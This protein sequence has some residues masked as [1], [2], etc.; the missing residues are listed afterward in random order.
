[1]ALNAANAHAITIQVSAWAGNN[2]KSHAQIIGAT[3]AQKTQMQAAISDLITPGRECAGID[4]LCTLPGISTVTICKFK[5]SKLQRNGFVLYCSPTLQTP[6][7]GLRR[8]Y[9]LCH[10]YT[11]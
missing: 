3:L 9:S 11:R 10:R 6:S 5:H 1:M 2:A 7:G 4:A 8:F